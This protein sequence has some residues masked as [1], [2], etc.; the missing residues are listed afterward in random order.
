MSHKADGIARSPAA[1]IGCGTV[2]ERKPAQRRGFFITRWEVN[3]AS[4]V[5]T[6]S[7]CAGDAGHRR[8][9]PGFSVLALSGKA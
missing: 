7:R 6:T 9:R 5:R 2:Q 1:D 8:D 4:M 3:G